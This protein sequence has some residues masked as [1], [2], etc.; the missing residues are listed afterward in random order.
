MANN[1]KST[2]G[3]EVDLESQPF[4]VQTVQPTVSFDFDE[5]DPPSPAYVAVNDQL[6]IQSIANANLANLIVNVLL[7]RPDDQIVPLTF[8]YGLSGAFTSQSARFQL[9]EGFILSVNVQFGAGISQGTICFAIVSLV[10]QPFGVAQQFR[11]LCRGYI[12]FNSGMSYPQDA[13]QRPTDGPGVA[14]SVNVANPGAGADWTFTVEAFARRRLV[15]VTATLTA[16]VAVANR[17]VSLIIDDGANVLANI[18]T[19]VTLVAST[20]NTYTF[21]DGLVITT[22]FN[23]VSMAPTPGNA[24]LGNGWRIRS[25]TTGIQPADQWSAINLHFM[26]WI[27][28]V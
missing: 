9:M 12:G 1:P 2:T 24:M 25:S 3:G 8:Q 5:A 28:R 16:A 23:N 19:G 6:L 7:L 17:L 15:S 13:L 26:T 27:D 10:R 18:P 22:P 4:A 14:N 21:G 11:T 20:A